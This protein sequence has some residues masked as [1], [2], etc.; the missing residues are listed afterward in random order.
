MKMKRCYSFR[1]MLCALLLCALLLCGCSRR[2]AHMPKHRKS[3]RCNCPTFSYLS[4]PADA[5]AP[6]TVAY[7][8]PTLFFL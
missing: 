2:G 8:Y 4:V 7:V 3:R 6:A 1:A 5:T